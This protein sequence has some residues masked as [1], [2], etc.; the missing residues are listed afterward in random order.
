MA[1]SDSSSSDRE[2]GLIVLQDG[3]RQQTMTRVLMLILNYRY[4][5][6]LIR[7][8]S[9]YE[10]FSTV[11]KHGRRVRCAVVIQDRKIDS[12]KSIGSLSEEG[13]IP[14]FLVLP[15]HLLDSHRELCQRIDNIH[16]C[17]WERALSQG[18]DSMASQIE[19][20]FGEQ[21]IGDLFSPETQALPYEEVQKL[22]ERRL[23]HLKTLPT[24]PQV[25][26]RIMAMINDGNSTVE[27]LEE[28]LTSD[29]AIVHKLL[30]VVN[31]PLFAGSGHKGGWTLQEAIVRLGRKK[32]GTIAQQIKLMTS[33]VKPQNGLFNIRRFWEHSVGC[34]IIADRLYREKLV[35]LKSPV[36]FNDYW[37]GSLLHDSGKLVLGFFFWDHFEDL[38]GQMDT[39]KSTFRQAEK[40]LC[41]VGNHEFLGRLLLL[42]SNVGE[43]LVEAVGTH[44]EAGSS[45]AALTCLIHMAN[46]L[47]KDV[48]KGYLPS[49][50]S[51][52]SAQVLAALGMQRDD[53]R[54]LQQTLGESIV[55]EIDDL[56]DRCTQLP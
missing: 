31:S 43:Q 23:N 12:R 17:P 45:P 5:L 49:E 22:V 48:G 46:N 52:Y 41:E 19:T 1:E 42:K 26:L 51:V 44:H 15:E 18:D 24:L 4:G 14:V 35:R 32:V 3:K 56:V 36:D 47:C 37:I 21:G 25:A 28:V 40:E 54:K 13:R 16:Y 53:V 11:Q 10:G 55:E 30:Q 33:L 20:V 34:A 27:D 2:Y 38:L 8:G 50:P 29:P 39:G 7:V 9:F 6:D